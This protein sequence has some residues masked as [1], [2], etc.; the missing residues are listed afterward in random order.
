MS[1]ALWGRSRQRAGEIFYEQTHNGIERKNT[2]E[3][4]TNSNETQLERPGARDWGSR[5]GAGA[6]HH[7]HHDGRAAAQS[8]A[9]KNY[10]LACLL[11]VIMTVS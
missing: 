1:G 10:F 6:G 4:T 2:Y 11:S 9:Q 3:Q 7:E 8:S 5:A